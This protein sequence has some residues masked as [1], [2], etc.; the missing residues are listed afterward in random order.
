MYLLFGGDAFYPYGG[1]Y[2]FRGEFDSVEKAKSK[3]K[4]EWDFAHIIKKD[5]L[6]CVYSF[7]GTCYITDGVVPPN[8]A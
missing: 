3:I 4:Q 8:R 1:W 5:G 6:V 7:G 2:D